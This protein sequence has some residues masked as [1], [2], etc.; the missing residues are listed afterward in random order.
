MEEDREEEM[1]GVGVCESWGE[2]KKEKKQRE[3]RRIMGGGPS[4][5]LRWKSFLGAEA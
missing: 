1:E 4:E 3:A 5:W 2:K